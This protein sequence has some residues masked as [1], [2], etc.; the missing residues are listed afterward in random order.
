MVG[1]LSVLD[2][3]VAPPNPD[4]ND[5]LMSDVILL[6]QRGTCGSKM[7]NKKVEEV[8]VAIYR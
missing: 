7:R 8:E 1:D 2:F 3:Q 6:R 4:E 5:S